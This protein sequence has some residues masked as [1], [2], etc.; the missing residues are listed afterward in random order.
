MS[1]FA[2]PEELGPYLEEN[3]RAL[4]AI[5]E[6]VDAS[7]M[8]VFGRLEAL[9]RTWAHLHRR[10]LQPYGINYAELT[11]LGMLRTAPGDACTPSD[12]RGLPPAPEEVEPVGT[13]HGAKVSS[14][15]SRAHTSRVTCWRRVRTTE[16]NRH[17]TESTRVALRGRGSGSRWRLR[18]G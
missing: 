10:L 15:P 9:A 12:L 17:E 7:P 8:V 14:A 18:A 11:T 2:R 3:A 4:E 6:G 13:V 16:K 1:R 5:L